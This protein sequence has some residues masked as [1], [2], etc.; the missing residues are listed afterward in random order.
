MDA[1]FVCSYSDI[2]YR[3]SVVQRAL[4]HPGDIVLCVD[5]EWRPAISIALSIRKTTLKK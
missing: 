3:S 1:G 2:L 4:A 5:T